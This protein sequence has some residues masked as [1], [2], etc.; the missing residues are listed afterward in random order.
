M[1]I[2]HMRSLLL[3]LLLAAVPGVRAEAGFAGLQPGPHA[4]GFRVVQQYDYTRTYKDRVDL[5]TGA[6][7]VG[8]RARPIQT[9]VW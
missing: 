1:K 6:P 9:L 4:V 2:G 7:S 5:V 8:E 3:V